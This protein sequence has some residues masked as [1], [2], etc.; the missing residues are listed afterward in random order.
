MPQTV[1]ERLCC[2]L[3][4]VADMCGLGSRIARDVAGLAGNDVTQKFKQEVDERADAIRAGRARR[5]SAE[6][7]RCHTSGE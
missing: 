6:G 5:K 7:A 1:V 2:I 3:E 4:D